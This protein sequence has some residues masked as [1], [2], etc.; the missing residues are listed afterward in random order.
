M[1]FLW[2][3]VCVVEGIVVGESIIIICIW[4]EEGEGFGYC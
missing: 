3:N 2:W 1:I 4:E